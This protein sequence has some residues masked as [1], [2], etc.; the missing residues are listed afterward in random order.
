MLNRKAILTDVY[1]VPD[2]SSA[3]TGIDPKFESYCKG[4]NTQLQFVFEAVEP[5]ADFPLGSKITYRAY[6][7]DEVVVIRPDAEETIKMKASVCH[8]RSYPEQTTSLVNEDTVVT[9]EGMYLLQAMPQI[10]S[11]AP[12]GFT[13]GS[14]AEFD[15]AW[16]SVKSYFATVAPD[17]VLQ[18]NEWEKTHIP[19]TDCCQEYIAR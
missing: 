16:G 11:I 7:A 3:L 2:Y 14:R 6:S 9:P 10:S 4:D 13:K 18:W 15:K 19:S 12:Q 8:V 17:V 1:V 5:S